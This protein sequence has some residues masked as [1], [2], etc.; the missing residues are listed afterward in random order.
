MNFGGKTISNVR[1]RMAKWLSFQQF[2]RN[3]TRILRYINE[4]TNLSNLIDYFELFLGHALKDCS[5]LSVDNKY[6]L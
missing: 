5:I 2:Y 3:P 1:S 6:L 4:I